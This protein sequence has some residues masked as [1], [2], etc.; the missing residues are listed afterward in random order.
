MKL[1]I[2]M[3]S[4]G[5]ISGCG[6]SSKT[7]KNKMENAAISNRLI[8][9]SS[10]YL[11]QHANNPV[12]WY[13][14]GKE[15]LSKA[16]NEDKP[17]LVSIG[18]SSCHW[19]H[20]MA[21]ESFENDS[22]AALMNANFVNIKI[23][24]EERPDIDQIY[25]EAVQAMGINGGWPLNV[26]LTPDQKP[27]YGGTYF[28]SK[29]WRELLINVKTVFAGNRDKLEE[30]AEVYTKAI[31]ANVSEK[32]QLSPTA[33]TQEKID[34][35][36]QKLAQSF[37]LQWGGLKKAPK[38]IM[39]SQWSFLMDLAYLNP[40]LNIQ[41]HLELTL[42]KI[43]DGGIYDQIGGGFSRYSVDEFWHVP[44]FEKMLYDN[45]QLLSLYAKAYK[46]S[47]NERY[48]SVI[49]ETIQWLIREMLDESGGFYAALD[50]DSAGEEGK[51]YVWT[52][53]EIK[54]LA[55]EHTALIAA[56]YDIQEKGNWESTNIPRMLH[57][58][59]D[60]AT[61]FGLDLM[62]LQ[63]IITQFKQRALLKRA[64][65][66]RPG[67]DNKI[68][69]GWNGLTLTGILEAYQAT[70]KTLYLTLAKKNYNFILKN[71]LKDGTLIHVV[72]LSTQGFA[73]DYAAIIQA[74][75]KYY[76]TTFDKE[77]LRI[78]NNLTLQM[79]EQFYDP[80]EKLFYFT[81]I[82]AENLIARKNGLFD[83]VIP[84]SNSM[85]AE[86]LLKLG[87]HL[88]NEPYKKQ[89]L[90]MVNQVGKM[91][92][93][94]ISYLSQWASVATFI[95][96]PIPEIVIFGDNYQELTTALNA[97]HIPRKVVAASAIES[98]LPLL[99]YK[100]EI[101][102]KTAIYVCYNKTCKFPVT[103]LDKA[104]TQISSE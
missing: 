56:Y 13:P 82:H 17:I 79:N 97:L 95:V 46:M 36:Y 103:D 12:D 26:F 104:L 65:R 98:D 49:H 8:N 18:Y 4:L 70:G 50:A 14:W 52:Y 11:L 58:E 76:E 20:V 29:G 90:D 101:K 78:S 47:T 102:G 10:P 59:D 16:K 35:G 86:N 51:F 60:I 69:S 44:H 94:E 57:S 1:L 99:Q 63:S 24:R 7:T 15:A 6:S 91:M 68:I 39:P 83:N 62:T 92:A 64:E 33:I 32:Y 87:L 96:K 9:A 23:D 71:L 38:F 37:D 100:T 21:H 31:N 22:I 80:Q 89:A 43:I 72:N 66:I 74:L 34:S 93:Q 61:Q 41:P 54:K 25:M 84:S 73:E 88:D 67:L 75:I 3:L 2:I 48:A 30:S 85:M 27:F 40:T 55:G 19:C 28:P 81:S 77:A 53:D 42:N 5:L 45:G